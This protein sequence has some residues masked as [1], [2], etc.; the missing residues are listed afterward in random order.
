MTRT[1]A[2]LDLGVGNLHSVERALAFAARSCGSSIEI[3]RGLAPDEL[4]AADA[5]VAPGQGGFSVGAAAL[6]GGLGEVLVQELR[7]GTPYFGICLGL[8]LLFETS[9][10]APGAKGLGW[11]RGSVKALDPTGVK[12]PHMG[13]NQ[14]EAVGAPHRYLQALGGD[15]SWAYFI[16]SFHAQAKEDVVVATCSHGNNLVTAAVHR[17]NV[18]A[19]QFHPEKSQAGGLRM[20]TAFLEDCP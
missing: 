8:Q 17:D 5:I 13:W 3:R 11:F 19:T 6:A 2:L 20:L 12:I 18:F 1:V 16:H 15:G 9:E 7:Q 10:E 14:V 4:A